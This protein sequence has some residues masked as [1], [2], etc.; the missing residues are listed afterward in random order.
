MGKIPY[1]PMLVMAWQKITAWSV[2]RKFLQGRGVDLRYL[3]RTLK[4]PE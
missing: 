2:L 4:K 3:A 1:S